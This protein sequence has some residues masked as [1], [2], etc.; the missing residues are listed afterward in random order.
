MSSKSKLVRLEE[1]LT[2]HSPFVPNFPLNLD[3][4]MQAPKWRPPVI[5]YDATAM[6]WLNFV[7]SQR[8][9]IDNLDKYQRNILKKYTEKFYK[10]FSGLENT[11]DKIKILDKSLSLAEIRKEL[12]SII[13]NKEIG[14]GS[15]TN[16]IAFIGIPEGGKKKRLIWS[17]S[18]NPRQA[19]SLASEPP[20]HK[21]RK[22]VD[23][24]NGRTSSIHKIFEEVER[25]RNQSGIV[26]VVRLSA[27]SPFLYID[28][29]AKHTEYGNSLG[30]KG[31]LGSE[32]EI[33]LLNK[34]LKKCDKI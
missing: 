8:Q 19:A 30:S 7:N 9:Y 3:T 32:H 31:R 10:L 6:G 15:M 5:E 20:K 23:H 22:S 21:V 4:E 13:E 29:L 28:S 24:K 1:A 25:S 17:S 2:T 26:R 34:Y 16:M 14:A 27:Y 18:I 12:I 33:L 11:K